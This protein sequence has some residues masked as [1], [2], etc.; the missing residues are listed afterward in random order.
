MHNVLL[1]IVGISI[2]L[3]ELTNIKNSKKDVTI[4]NH[5]RIGVGIVAIAMGVIAVI[6]DA[7][8]N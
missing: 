4:Y 2:I 5:L 7:P 1:I 3:N 6:Y 8:W